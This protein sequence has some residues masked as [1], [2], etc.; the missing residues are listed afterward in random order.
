MPIAAPN[1]M[2]SGIQ[3]KVR[4]ITRSPSQ[5]QLT[6]DDLNNYINTF[7]LYNLP[8][9]LRLFS[10]RTNLTFYTQPGVDTY[11]T[12]TNSND[13]L[14]DF[15]NKYMTVH[16]SVYV[17]GVLAYF[18]QWPDTFF[19]NYP[20][21]RTTIDTTLRGNGTNG[22]FVGNLQTVNG[23]NPL[24]ATP[25]APTLVL[26][27]TVMFSAIDTNGQAMII[28][29]YPIDNVSG[30]LSVA[31]QSNPPPLPLGT[32]NYLTG[33]FNFTFPSATLN[34]VNNIVW[35]NAY[36]YVPGLPLSVL[37]F[38]NQFVL[39]PI[40]DKVYPVEL[41][42]DIIPT[43]FLNTTDNPQIKQWWQYISLGS[44]LLIFQDRMDTDSVNA[45]MPEFKEQEAMVNRTNLVQLANERTVTIY[46][47]AKNYGFGWFSNNWPY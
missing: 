43:Q 7:L 20:E 38:N 33:A 25:G 1:S 16:P 11:G 5:S 6:D 10:L 9:N 41:Q 31:N 30:L 12:S 23:N 45:I 35:S 3:Q 26:Q 13:P 24:I 32:I 29:D 44:A 42:A 22:P 21:V 4:R 17:S 27:N 36:Y 18:T 46:T 8:A 28:V 2:L 40:P 39:R 37:Y 14:F 19:G 15:Q 47:I 34:N